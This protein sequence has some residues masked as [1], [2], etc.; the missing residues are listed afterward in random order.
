MASLTC[1]SHSRHPMW[2]VNRC[3]TMVCWDGGARPDSDANKD[4]KWARKCGSRVANKIAD[5][6]TD[7]RAV[8]DFNMPDITMAVT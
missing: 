2:T 8:A 3:R 7:C 4:N 5:R 6:S 1:C